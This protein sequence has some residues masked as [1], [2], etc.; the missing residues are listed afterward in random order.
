MKF[1]ICGIPCE[2]AYGII[3]IRSL[4]LGTS[5]K[6]F[7][8]AMWRRNY[9]DGLIRVRGARFW[10]ETSAPDVHIQSDW[11]AQINLQATLTN[12]RFIVVLEDRIH[13]DSISHTIDLASDNASQIIYKV[14]NNKAVNQEF[15][16][17]RRMVA[18]LRISF[19]L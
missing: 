10:L 6:W 17:D 8:I 11:Y 5:Y 2:H 9:V 14:I 3:F 16:C 13:R 4:R 1:K 18:R 15:V 12:K 7:I 19:K